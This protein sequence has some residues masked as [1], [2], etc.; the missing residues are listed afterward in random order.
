M[1][2]SITINET[3]FTALQE[4]AAALGLTPEQLATEIVSRELFATD[5]KPK[6]QSF[7]TAVAESMKANEELLRRLAK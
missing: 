6:G 5:P 2:L 4:R 3:G 1:T 7:D